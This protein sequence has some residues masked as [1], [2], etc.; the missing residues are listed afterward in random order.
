MVRGG[1]P[2]QWVS[3]KDIGAVA[4]LCFID[5]NK[6]A[7]QTVDLAGGKCSGDELAGE[8]CKMRG[9]QKFSYQIAWFTRTIIYFFAPMVYDERVRFP[10]EVGGFSADLAPLEKISNDYPECF[11]RKGPL[12][13]PRI[14]LSMG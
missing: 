3:T 7:G 1:V 6:F 8:I 9:E 5:T 4:A 13:Y 14:L 2:M 10:T 11:N 12:T